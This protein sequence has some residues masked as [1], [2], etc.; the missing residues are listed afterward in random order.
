M[1]GFC[2]AKCFLSST[3]YV[4]ATSPY[5]IYLRVLQGDLNRKHLSLL[6]ARTNAEIVCIRSSGDL[7]LKDS[8]PTLPMTVHLALMCGATI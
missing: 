6:P 7:V 8:H 1:L 5:A 3:I 2:A 4:T